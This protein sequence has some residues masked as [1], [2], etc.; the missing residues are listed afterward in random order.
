[1]KVSN[2]QKTRQDGVTM[3]SAD[4]LP[5][6]A[7]AALKLWYR[8]DT[9]DPDL[10]TVGDALAAG[11]ATPCMYDSESLWVDAPVSGTLFR[12]LSR[13]Q[14]VLASWYPFMKPVPI[15]GRFIAEVPAMPAKGPGV[16]CCFSAGVDSWYSLLKHQEEITHLLLVRG[17]DISLDNEALWNQTKAQIGGIAARLGKRLITCET[18]LRDIAD[19]RRCKWG[20]PCTEDFWG[21]CLHGSA[22]ASVG[23]L[24]GSEIR[25]MIVPA[26]HVYNRLRPWGSSPLLDQFWSNDEVEL[27]HDGCE[28]DRLKKTFTIA[29]C[30]LAL[31]TLRVCYYN[32]SAYNCGRCEKC[33]RTQLA[34]RICGVVHRA[35]TF[36][37]QFSLSA[38]RDLVIPATGLQ[39]YEEL[40][41]EAYRVNDREL[42][43]AL[44]IAIGQ[45]FS[46]LRTFTRGKYLIRS[47]LNAW[48]RVMAPLIEKSFLPL[49]R[50]RA[51]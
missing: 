21:Q 47:W 27:I 24:L 2:I 1:M 6:S 3:I 13:A 14:E 40:M 38:I 17:F 37:E 8:F 25:T 28:A 11:L 19:K 15:C 45:R 23:L 33:L 44:R 12:N 35:R 48:G 51:G 18:N 39:M 49:T 43:K 26:S 22:L 16:I 7:E 46:A 36:P 9:V 4:V 50:R 29:S 32:T 34:L 42:A 5:D 31:E 41:M 20:R 10:E 30:D